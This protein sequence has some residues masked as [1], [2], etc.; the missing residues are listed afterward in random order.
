LAFNAL[1]SRLQNGIKEKDFGII[2]NACV[3]RASEKLKK[4]ILKTKNIN[5]LFQ[6]FAENTEHCNWLNIRYLEV[7]A[8][9]SRNDQLSNLVYNYKTAIY[10]KT[11]R[12]V[13]DYI[14]YQT[15]RE[16]YYSQLQTKFDG[17]DPDNVTVEQLKRKCE[18][19]L[20]KEIA[21]LITV[22]EEDSLRITWLIPTD[23]VFQ[24]YLS[25]LMMPQ[26]SRL[27]SYLQIGDWVAHHPLHVLQNLHKEH[28]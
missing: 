25:A 20:I 3:N 26:E 11:L 22:I 7:I 15:V 6:L 18:P 28:R 2:K 10:S 9:A 4:Q 5:S 1:L 16:K 23:T 21:M 12:E 27:D 8:T 14:P 17:K 24:T 13:W 19:Y